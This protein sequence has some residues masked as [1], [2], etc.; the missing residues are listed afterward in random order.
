MLTELLRK[1]IHLS[2]L[3]VLAVY[4]I[5]GKD[6]TLLLIAPIAAMAFFLD[7]SRRYNNHLHRFFNWLFSSIM[8]PDELARKTLAG[9][10]YFMIA[11]NI[12]VLV[13]N[14]DIAILSLLAL[15]FGD[16]AASLIGK[17]FGKHKIGS[18][19]IEGSC[20]FLVSSIIA[21]IVAIKFGFVAQHALFSAMIGCFVATLV[22]LYSKILKI[23]DNL[24]IVIGF[25]LAALMVY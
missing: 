14:K 16:S 3:W 5:F 21:C 4:L 25:G 23:D 18:K 15:I 17:K 9:S 8:R 11:A 6:I 20:A 13:F 19:S 2:S 12:A 1:L 10:T 7:M 24:L 22:E